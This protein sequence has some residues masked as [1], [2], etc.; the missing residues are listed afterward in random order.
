MGESENSL[1]T[2]EQTS[3]P[4]RKSVTL[5]FKLSKNYNSVGASTGFSSSRCIGETDEQFFQRVYSQCEK[6]FDILLAKAK[7]V[8]G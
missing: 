2:L 5:E 3:E 4:D 1:V 8:L 6:E 7:K